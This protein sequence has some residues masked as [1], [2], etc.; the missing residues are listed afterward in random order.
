MWEVQWEVVYNHLHHEFSHNPEVVALLEENI[1]LAEIA[2]EE[3]AAA[4]AAAAAAAA[5]TDGAYY[6]YGGDGE[7]IGE[8]LLAIDADGDGEPDWWYELAPGVTH[9]EDKPFYVTMFNHGTLENKTASGGDIFGFESNL[10]EFGY[11]QGTDTALA[12]WV[13]YVRFKVLPDGVTNGQLRENLRAELGVTTTEWNDSGISNWL[14]QIETY[15][16]QL[17][18]SGAVDQWGSTPFNTWKN[19]HVFPLFKSEADGGALANGKSV[20]DGMTFTGNVDIVLGFKEIFNFNPNFMNYLHQAI[21]TIG[22]KY[23]QS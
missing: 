22:A 15:Y 17:D 4:D 9:F 7:G 2:K 6:Y 16:S 12:E 23:Q 18:Y 13:D 11:G 8:D 1:S 20:L 3:K 5:S 21:D 14:G 10:R 19:I